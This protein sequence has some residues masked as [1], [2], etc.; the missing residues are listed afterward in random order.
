MGKCD[1]Q[2]LRFGA[3]YYLRVE[4]TT[5]YHVKDY[6][7]FDFAHRI[8]RV[9]DTVTWSICMHDKLAW[10][11]QFI[12][13]IQHYRH[14]ADAWAHVNVITK[15]EHEDIIATTVCSPVNVT[16]DEAVKLVGISH[17]SYKRTC[18]SI[19]SVIKNQSVLLDQ[20]YF[21]IDCDDVSEQHEVY[22]SIGI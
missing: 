5:V 1:I 13:H 8:I 18:P 4:F 12:Q 3:Q 9:S 14:M 7:M 20:L 22:R 21:G 11:P 2:Y 10:T 15:A 16:S 6:R 19:W 17:Q